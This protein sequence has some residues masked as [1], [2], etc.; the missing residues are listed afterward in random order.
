MKRAR[1]AWVIHDPDANDCAVGLLRAVEVPFAILGYPQCEEVFRCGVSS[2]IAAACLDRIIELFTLDIESHLVSIGI[3]AIKSVRLHQ[4]SNDVSSA[5]YR[6]CLLVTF[7]L[8]SSSLPSVD[9]SDAALTSALDAWLSKHTTGADADPLLTRCLNS[10]E[11]QHYLRRQLDNSS[12]VAFV[13]N[14]SILPLAMS[15]N[16]MTATGWRDLVS[17][18]KAVED[19]SVNITGSYVPFMSPPSL[20]AEFVLPNRGSVRGMLV[21]AGVVV[22]AG[23]GYH[24]KST[25]LSALKQGVFDHVPGHSCELVLCL[26]R[27]HSI[28]SEEGRVVSGVDITPFISELPAFAQIDPSNFATSHAS[29]S[30]SMAANVIE[31]LES[32]AQLLLLDEDTCATNFMIRDSRMRAL[33]S[34]E[35]ITPFI[36]RVNG[37]YR[38]HNISTVVVIGGAGDW[39]DVQN[40]T[41]LMDNYQTLDRTSR[42]NSISKSFCTGRVQYNGRGLVHQLPWPVEVVSERPVHPQQLVIASVLTTLQASIV[43]QSD[44]T[45]KCSSSQ[46]PLRCVTVGQSRI[47]HGVVRISGASDHRRLLIHLATGAPLEIDFASFDQH[48]NTR[49]SVMGAGFALVYLLLRFCVNATAGEEMFSVDSICAAYDDLCVDP[50]IRSDPL[51]EHMLS[52]CEGVVNTSDRNTEIQTSMLCNLCVLEHK[53]AFVFALHR[54]RGLRF[55]P[56]SPTVDDQK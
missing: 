21:P 6:M 47:R 24:G 2:V 53:R 44:D 49:T 5:G 46:S 51:C 10:L 9:P 37:L 12:G 38:Q 55:V 41:L 30:T 20:E 45:L 48:L 1:I 39:F 42:A 54:V 36:Y 15:G 13:P 7:Q 17:C 28:R 32:D 26:S 4:C 3:A 50:T 31:A 34:H 43:S 14:R 40:C 23:G 29:G 33:V 11:D 35:P 27:A 19:N 56:V 16:T 18:I 22:I 25:L 52:L 8:P